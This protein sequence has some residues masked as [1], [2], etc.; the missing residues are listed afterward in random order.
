MAAVVTRTAVAVAEPNHYL[1]VCGGRDFN[2][3]GRVREP[4]EI[5]HWVYGDRL[6]IMHGAAD[7]ADRCAGNVADELGIPSKPFPADWTGPCDPD[8]CQS[9]HRKI[10]KGGE[11]YCPAA[12][13]RRNR[14]M[15]A[16]LLMCRRK[17]HS[18]QVLAFPGG[19]G[20]ADMIQVAESHDIHVDRM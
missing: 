13:P 18:V 20:T 19:V 15:L 5:L 11:E 10:R 3:Y 8:F 9:G 2:E 1:L 16:Y 7:G 17:G 12:G 4:I 6:R 14:Q